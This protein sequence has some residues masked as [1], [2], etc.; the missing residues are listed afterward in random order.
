M[1]KLGIIKGYYALINMSALGYLCNRLF[2]KLRNTNPEKEKEII[3]YCVKSKNWW[4]VS[5]EGYI[6]LGIGSWEKTLQGI[7]NARDEFLDKFSNNIHSFEQ[8][9]YLGFYIYRR[10]YLTNKRIKDTKEIN[11]ITNEKE[12]DNIDLKILNYISTNARV[13]TINIA[14]DLKLAI[15]TVT[16]RIKKL[17]EKKIIEAFRV[18]LDLN[19]LNYYWY[20]ISFILKDNTKKK[21]LLNYFSL[22]PNIVFAFETSGKYN[23]EVELE[24]ESNE[25]FKKIL[26]DIRTKF[27]D[28]IESYD[29]LLWN[30]EHK[31]VLFNI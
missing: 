8:S 12:I 25:Q 17:Q 21:E 1:E 18:T 7:K 20:K 30:K 22:H 19:Q 4:V 15:N 23:V 31:Y 11:Y 2:F 14:R 16:D 3:D 24:V 27:S 28:V 6:N 26:D 29:S 10:A 5:A 9:T 13:P